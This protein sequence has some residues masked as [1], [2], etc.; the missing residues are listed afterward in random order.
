MLPRT[1]MSKDT[2]I[3]KWIQFLKSNRIV[4]MQ[5]DPDT[6][7]LEYLKPVTTKELT[8]FLKITTDFS[9]EEIGNAIKTALTKKGAA[10]PKIQNTPGTNVDIQKTQ[11]VKS[12]PAKISGPQQTVPKKKYS[13]DDATDIEF[14]DINEAI[15]DLAGKS[16][17]E[18]DVE[19]IFA[20]LASLDRSKPEEQD[21]K[22]SKDLS[23]EIEKIKNLIDNVMTDGQRKSL[24]RALN[25]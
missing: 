16:L 15:A 5:S 12:E 20:M 2:L 9:D 17:S 25:A 11:P 10:V 6:G 7:K 18:D 3:E 8:R 1:P 14:K 13:K 22:P 4:A 24:W 19:N 23:N 21:T